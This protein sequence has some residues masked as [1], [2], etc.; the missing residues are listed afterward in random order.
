MSRRISSIFLPLFCL[1]SIAIVFVA[2]IA[3]GPADLYEKDQPKTLAYTTDILLHGRFALPRDVIY[4]PATKPPLYNWIAAAVMKVTG[5]WC[6]LAMKSPS[7][8]GAVGVAAVLALV[9]RYSWHGSPAR[10][11]PKGEDVP[12]ARATRG[13]VVAALAC[14]IWFSF[15]VDIRHGSVIRLMFLARPDMLQAFFLTGAWAAATLAMKSRMPRTPPWHPTCFWLC[16]SCAMLTKGPLA[17]LAIVYALLAA[18]LIAGSW[19]SIRVLHPVVGTFFTLTVVGT[20]FFF[21]YRTDPEHIRSVMLG[22]EIVDRVTQRTPEGI[23]KPIWY[24]AMWFVSK[25]GYFSIFA[26]LTLPVIAV[27]KRWFRPP[28]AV[29][30]GAAIWLV[31]LLVGLSLP[32][33]KRIDYLLPTF[34]PAAYL[35]ARLLVSMCRRVS[36][37]V[38]LAG[39]L[40]LWMAFTLGRANLNSFHEAREHWSDRAT[41]FAR[42]VR[43]RVRD[44]EPLIVIVRGK[45]PLTT[46]LHRHQGSVLDQEQLKTARWI[47]LPLI[48]TMARPVTQSELIPLGFE[49]LENRPTGV[50]GLFDM[51]STDR[52]TIEELVAAQKQV[53]TWNAD[54]NPYR[55]RGTVWRD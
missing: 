1:A 28:D 46:L 31:V 32:A 2:R 25:G 54:E 33:G 18:K 52:P 43:E 11:E 27:H 22:A 55:S 5:S 47:V 39:L 10:L 36:I 30:L 24:S 23:A 3:V 41:V 37:P 49:V 15:G 45:H 29:S 34:A 51:R 8:L 7:V 40:P 35:A 48:D 20:W 6:E 42:D 17:L 16:I 38:A 14:A 21:A 26:L 13:M 53:A 9:S 19:R 12:E 4:Q 44:D 50:I